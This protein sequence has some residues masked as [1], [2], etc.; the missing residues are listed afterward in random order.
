MGERNG[1][2]ESNALIIHEQHEAFPSFHE[3]SWSSSTGRRSF[4]SDAGAKSAGEEE[5]LNSDLESPNETSDSDGELSGDEDD[6]EGAEL[7]LHVPDSEAG[8]LTASKR[9]SELFQAI[10]A[11]SGVSVGSALDKWVEE[12]KEINRTEIANAMLQLRRRRMYGR[13]MQVYLLL[14]KN[15]Q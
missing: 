10:V 15:F 6:I 5:D 4:S 9:S 2:F 8:K 14:N 3:R 13:A 7:E 12:G 11:F 1:S